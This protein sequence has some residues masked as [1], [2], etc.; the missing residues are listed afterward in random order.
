MDKKLKNTLPEAVLSLSVHDLGGLTPEAHAELHRMIWEAKSAGTLTDELLNKCPNAECGVC[1]VI[2]CPYRDV[3]HF[4][5][6]GCP[7][8]AK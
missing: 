4:H 1:A 5:H 6:D 2:V 8:C 7:S 3:L